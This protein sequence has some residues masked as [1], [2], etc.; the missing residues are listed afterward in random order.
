MNKNLAR[1]AAVSLLSVASLFPV[2][3]LAAAKV[4]VGKVGATCTKSGASGKTAKGS[5]LVCKRTGSKLKWAL[6][7]KKSGDTTVPSKSKTADTTVP[8]AKSA[9]TTVPKA[10]SADT[11]VPKKA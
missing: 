8:K 3:A 6:A 9:D 1:F 4:P 10:K 2:S 5:A 7:P 11:T